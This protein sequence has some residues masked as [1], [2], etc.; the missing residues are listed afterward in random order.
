[1]P[2]RVALTPKVS[3]CSLEDLLDLILL[4]DNQITAMAKNTNYQLWLFR[5]LDK[6]DFASV[7][8]VLVKFRLDLL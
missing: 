4:L 5:Q 7:T 8:H 2:Y 1:M 3:W 6:K